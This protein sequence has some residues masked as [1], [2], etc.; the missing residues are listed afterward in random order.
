MSKYSIDHIKAKY[1]TENNLKD[2]ITKTNT[3]KFS[4]MIFVSGSVRVLENMDLTNSYVVF[5]LPKDSKFTVR[6]E[7]QNYSIIRYENFA[8]SLSAV[9]TT[10]NLVLYRDVEFILAGHCKSH[11]EIVELI[12]PV[13]FDRAINYF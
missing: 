12:K 6:L 9:I 13:S 3:L 1:Q 7:P 10:M 5:L 8:T 11:K 4:S 2:L